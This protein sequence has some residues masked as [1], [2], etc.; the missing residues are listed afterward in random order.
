MRVY[1]ATK[2]ENAPRAEE[3]A[4]QLEAAGHIISYKWWE[5]SKVD[6]EQA[7][8]DAEGVFSAD[9]LVLIVEKD[10]RYSGALTEFGMAIA[11]GVPVY[12]MGNA[13]DVSTGASPNIFTLLPGVQHGIETLLDA[14]R[15]RHV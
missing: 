9:A 5:C 10:Y 8:C 15:A 4:A 14:T 2:W 12:I 3:V 13:L 7:L 6:S 1:I 11:W